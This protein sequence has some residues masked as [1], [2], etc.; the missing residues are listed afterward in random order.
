MCSVECLKKEDCFICDGLAF[1][2]PFALRGEIPHV[3]CACACTHTPRVLFQRY[4]CT[5]CT[6]VL[7]CSA[8]SCGSKHLSCVTVLTPCLHA[9]HR[10][11]TCLS[12]PPLASKEGISC[13]RYMNCP[14][15][16]VGGPLLV[17]PILPH[18]CRK[19]HGHA[20]HRTA[21]HL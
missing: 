13:L 18:N 12:P 9:N 7:T 19:V 5:Y 16:L 6:H 1:S 21:G 4:T 17:R 10:S 2:V 15:Q 20:S 3:A 11:P 14:S 8:C